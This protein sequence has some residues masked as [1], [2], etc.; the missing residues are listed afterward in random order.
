M[1]RLFTP[2]L[3]LTQFKKQKLEQI[4]MSILQKVEENLLC[5]SVIQRILDMCIDMKA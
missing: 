4:I 5:N 2:I 1:A 3:V